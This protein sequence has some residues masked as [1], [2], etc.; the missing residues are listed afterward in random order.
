MSS[1]GCEQRVLSVSYPKH[2]RRPEDILHFVE[3]DEFADD[4]DRIGLNCEDDAISLQLCTMSDPK[5][6]RIIEGT[7]GLRLHIHSF[8]ECGIDKD[9]IGV[10]YVFFEEY[11]IVYFVCLDESAGPVAFSAAQIRRFRDLL[12]RIKE[13]LDK[14]KLLG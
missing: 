10:Y 12:S 13:G 3:A 9:D 6:W 7:G 8:R 1:K 4:W 5:A 2:F 11:G 14:R